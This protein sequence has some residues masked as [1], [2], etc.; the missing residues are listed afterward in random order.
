MLEA[1]GAWWLRKRQSVKVWVRQRFLLRWELQ[2]LTHCYT[3]ASTVCV[4]AALQVCISGNM[5]E[6][7]PNFGLC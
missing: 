4:T 1:S 7:T 6:L 5:R 2:F 3:E